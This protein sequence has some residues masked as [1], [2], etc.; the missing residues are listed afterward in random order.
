MARGLTK[1][2]GTR[3]HDALAPHVQRGDMPGVVALVARDDDVHVATIGHKSFDDP[4][5]IGR[6]AIFRIASITKPITGVT[7]MLLVQDGL[8]ALDDP[9]EWWLP[10]LADRRVLRTLASELDD[11]VPAVRSITV[12]DVLSFRL[13]WGLVFAPPDTLPI[14]AAE[15]EL[16]LHTFGAPWPPTNLTPDEWIRRLG[17]LPL[18]HQPGAGWAYNGGATVAGV[19]IERVAGAP[20]GDVMRERVFEP[21]GMVDSGFFVPPEKLDRFTTAY[22]PNPDTGAPELFDPPDGWWS[23]PPSMP[24]CSGWLVSTIDD[25]FAFASMFAAN[26]GDL[27]SPESVRAMTTD[28]MSD[29]D[30]AANRIFV[31]DHSG[32]G[33]AMA[34]PAGDGSTGI[35]GGFGWEGGTGT[36]WRTDPTA[37]ITGI[38][39]TQRAM[40]SPEPPPVM[41]DFWNVAY[42][43]IV[44]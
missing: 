38:L 30:R 13:G 29:A 16:E 22:A 10:E 25:L 6:D 26:G 1:D 19:L 15:R 2:A 20:I 4:E 44:H 43:A 32:W 36:S 27:L 14:Q 9:V 37:G 35:P 11:T 18:L 41:T 28:R 21:L 12:Q 8:M 5:P 3:V 40:T 24:D 42:A 33:F 34:V 17:T 7:A 39:F 23:R 31:G